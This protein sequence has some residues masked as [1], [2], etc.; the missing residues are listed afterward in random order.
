VVWTN[1]WSCGWQILCAIVVALGTAGC[2]EDD[3]PPFQHGSFDGRCAVPA[4]CDITTPKCQQAVLDATACERGQDAPALPVVRT[5]ARS[6]LAAEYR[7]EA[8]ADA[9]EAPESAQATGA[10]D[11]ALAA[12]H[13]LPAGTGVIEASID[14]AVDNVAAYYDP[15]DKRLTIIE[16]SAGPDRF[17]AMYTLSHELTHYLQDEALD[18]TRLHQEVGATTDSQVA[19]SA[20]VEGDAMVTSVR[21]AVRFQGGSARDVRW[22]DYF[23]SVQQSVLGAI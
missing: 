21:V 1:P 23:T 18:L 22:D 20:L 19:L 3:A 6:E 16:D 13:L 4:E 9:A 14:D 11:A 17:S 12:L 2:G 8:D 10:W 7:A 5:L 15:G